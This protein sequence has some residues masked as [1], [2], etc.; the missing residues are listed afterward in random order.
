M[1]QA[2]IEIKRLEKNR[3]NI[4]SNNGVDIDLAQVDTLVLLNSQ[5]MTTLIDGCHDGDDIEIIIVR[6][7]KEE[8]DEK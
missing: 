1:N 3:Y 8:D 5:L 6:Y 2:T 7:G 4:K